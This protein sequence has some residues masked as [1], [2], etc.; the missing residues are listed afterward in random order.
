MDIE[1][2][3][4]ANI[5]ILK[6]VQ[7]IFYKT[8]GMTISFSEL[9]EKGE[10]HFFP[11]EERA[12]FC[13]IIQST[14]SGKHRCYASDKKGVWKAIQKNSYC[15]YQCHAGLIDVAIPL[16]IKGEV[17]GAILTGQLLVEDPTEE[18]FNQI[19]QRVKSLNLDLEKLKEAYFQIKVFSKEKLEMAVKLLSFI[20]SYIIE[21]ENILLLQEKLIK[22]QQK[23]IVEINRKE[24]LRKRLREAMPLFR[25]E[26]TLEKNLNYSQRVVKEVKHFIE[27]NFNHPLNLKDVAKSVYANP[28]YLCHLFKK[29]IGYTFSQYILKVRIEKA[30]E[31]L[32]KRGWSVKKICH[33]VGYNDPNYFSRLFKKTVGVSPTE[34]REKLS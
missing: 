17:I 1:L 18:G 3:Q 23:L 6:G 13:K 20:G 15:I 28:Y 32:Q 7:S 14:P 5:G 22:Q 12:L 31:L 16:I 4:I 33:S 11:S 10:F 19:K 9:R 27:A 26:D 24:E 30:E 29:N 34:Y 8:T 25:I 21:R 2:K